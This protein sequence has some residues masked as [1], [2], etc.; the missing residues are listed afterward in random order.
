[1][2]NK[3]IDDRYR[4]F[5][6]KLAKQRLIEQRNQNAIASYAAFFDSLK[7]QVQNDVKA[8]NDLFAA[9][10][11]CSAFFEQTQDG[12]KVTRGT[13]L[14]QVKRS[15]GTVIS[16]EYQVTTRIQVQDAPNNLAFEVAADENGV[17]GYKKNGDFWTDTADVARV[18]LDQFLCG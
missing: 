14:M 6:E 10:P 17:I 15:S 1:M 9:H 3:W 12:F 13:L 18:I 5:Q 7:Q 4:I 2:A 8:Y 11:G 16:V